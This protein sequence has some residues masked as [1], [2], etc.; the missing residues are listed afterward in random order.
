MRALWRLYDTR[1]HT[2]S[3]PPWMRA[4]AAW[5]HV[6][7]YALLFALP[8][9]AINGA[10][11]EGH[12]LTLLAGARIAPL[13]PELHDV[14]VVI[15]AIH[16]WPGDAIVWLAGFH[17]LAGLYHHVVL[18]DGVLASMLPRWFPAVRR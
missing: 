2:P 16:A 7:L 14:G 4:A 8:L 5:T 13:L 1:P 17:A 3:G 12:P 10:W 15:A 6:T 11:L 18:G 9:T